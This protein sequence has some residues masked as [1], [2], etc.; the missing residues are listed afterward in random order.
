ML[1][2]VAGRVKFLLNVAFLQDIRIP[3]MQFLKLLARA[4]IVGLFLSFWVI[5]VFNMDSTPEVTFDNLLQWML[6]LIAGFAILLG[7]IFTDT[8]IERHGIF[9]RMGLYTIVPMLFMIYSDVAMLVMIAALVLGILVGF[10]VILFI[11]GMIVTTSILNRARVIMVLLVAMISFVLPIVW[12]VVSISDRTWTWIT[13]VLMIIIT[14]IVGK[15]YPRRV[16]PTFHQYIPKLPFK[17][18]FAGFRNAGVIRHALFFFF[19]S[20]NL[21]FH[22]ATAIYDIGASSEIATII[23]VM[24]VSTPVV[25][26]VLDHVGRKPV[27]YMVLLLVGILSIFFDYPFPVFVNW[28]VVRV[29]VYSFSVLVTILLMVIFAG[30]LSSRFSRGRIIG[31]LLF[32]TVLGAVL[33]SIIGNWF[34]DAAVDPSLMVIV[35]DW[36]TLSVFISTLLFATVN[37]T[38]QLGTTQWRDYLVR[39]QIIKQAAGISLVFKEFKKGPKDMSVMEDLISGGISGL[40]SIL[41]EISSSRKNIR[42]L[43]HGDLFLIFHHTKSSTAVAFVTRDLV[44]FREK[45]AAFH[46]HFEQ[47]NKD[48]VVADA[49]NVTA[50]KQVDW[51]IKRYFA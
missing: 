8:L 4:L 11:T 47:L 2:R 32:M 1:S 21:G 50:L 26:A 31:M 28:N 13:I 17:M 51:L 38:L 3:W 29:G 46:V 48:I 20:L 5:N 43:D 40:E 30:D 19:I 18:M 27:V 7:G 42:V 10:L 49:V 9:E 37:E 16:T 22:T 14:F 33:G 44:V 6:A 45:L 39:V 24:V 34:D 12:L 15:K 25:A 41:K 35:A 36:T 23:I